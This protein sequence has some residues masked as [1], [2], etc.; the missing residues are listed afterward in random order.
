MCV[1][2]LLKLIFR[3]YRD[4]YIID[5]RGVEHVRGILGR[6][7]RPLSYSSINFASKQQSIAGRLFNV[8]N[9]FLHSPGTDTA[10]VVLRGIASP[11]RVLKMI[12]SRMD[13]GRGESSGSA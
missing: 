5:S 13:E 7:A 6:E 11:K 4:K 2:Y 12:M 1:V 8:G 9:I 10:D 3:R